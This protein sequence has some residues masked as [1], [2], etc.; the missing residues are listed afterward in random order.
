MFNTMHC[1]LRG[2]LWW[3]LEAI[4]SS[5]GI[6]YKVALCSHLKS[7]LFKVLICVISN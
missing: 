4:A 6:E 7:N 5:S 1:I 3:P 2:S